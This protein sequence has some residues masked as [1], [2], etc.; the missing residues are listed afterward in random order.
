M[1]CAVPCAALAALALVAAL[2][3]GIAA[4]VP[5]ALWPSTSGPASQSGRTAALGPGACAPAP[6]WS[7]HFGTYGLLPPVVGPDGTVFVVVN[8]SAMALDPV[9]G[10]TRWSYAANGSDST[11]F[12]ECFGVNDAN[13]LL[14]CAGPPSGMGSASM[15]AVDGASGKLLWQT[16]PVLGLAASPGQVA[17][18][19]APGPD[20][21]LA[22][23][24]S[25][26]VDGWMQVGSNV[27]IERVQ[28]RRTPTLPELAPSLRHSV[29]CSVEWSWC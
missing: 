18:L 13:V 14:F 7:L 11:V 9:T 20:A 29:C 15:L 10:S 25:V 16:A 8:N 3:G 5:A 17:L 4:P 19:V 21:N 22:F 24:H 27:R 1:G 28:R 12:R 26:D 2:H 6:A 23:V